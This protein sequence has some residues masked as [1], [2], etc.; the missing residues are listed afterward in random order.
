MAKKIKVTVV[1]PVLN[2][3]KTIERCI[4]SVQNQS[5]VDIE[6]IVIDGDS[7]DG[8][9]CIV[10]KMGVRL[11][12]ELDAGIY[13][14]FNKGIA[15]ASGDVIHILNADDY[16]HNTKV[17]DDSVK[18]IEKYDADICHGLV[19]QVDSEGNFVWQVGID[20]EKKHLMKKMKVAHPSMFVRRSVYEKFGNYSVGFKIAADHEFVLR[21]WDK[22]KVTYI[23]KPFCK[24]SIGGVSTSN[25]EK[26]YRESAAARLM[27]GGGLITTVLNYLWQVYKH[28][29]LVEP[30]RKM[31]YRRK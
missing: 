7:T 4:R 28:K 12:S 19:E 24:M 11:I 23:D 29:Y 31:G 27:H 14:A 17:I 6:H 13:D 18:A 22:V 2:G 16:Y 5:Y 1:T 9:Q 21:V 15:A 30:M 26:S 3:A 20:T 25:V 8:T 10:N